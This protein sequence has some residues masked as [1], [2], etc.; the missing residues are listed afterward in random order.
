M[1]MG[2][3]AEN[4]VNMAGWLKEAVNGRD[5][6]VVGQYVHRQYRSHW[7]LEDEIGPEA[8]RV[9]LRRFFTAFP[10]FKYDVHSIVGD[11][12]MVAVFGTVSGTFEAEYDGTAPT[13]KKFEANSVEFVRFADGL[14]IEHWGVFDTPLYDQ[15]LGI[16]SAVAGVHDQEANS[17]K[18][19][20]F[21][22]RLFIQHDRDAVAELTHPEW[23]DPSEQ[24]SPTGVHGQLA[25]VDEV[26]AAFPHLRLE[27]K[28]VIAEEDRVAVYSTARG[29]LADADGTVQEGPRAE[30]EAVDY[31]K[32]KDGKVSEHWILLG[33]VAV[34]SLA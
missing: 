31:F 5:L 8:E 1:R 27:T 9:T 28:E 24:G 15:Q 26:L 14:A 30:S 20:E 33:H 6:D 3:P 19:R 4:I 7:H 11:R 16:Q 10:D 25:Q 29:V 17:R 18:A 22:D 12:D 21:I 23:R 2:S 32:F 13:G 34:G